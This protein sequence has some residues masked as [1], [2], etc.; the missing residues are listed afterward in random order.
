MPHTAAKNAVYFERHEKLAIALQNVREEIARLKSQHET[1]VA[2]SSVQSEFYVA[3]GDWTVQNV[4]DM[5]DLMAQI[6]NVFSNIQVNAGFRGHIL[7]PFLTNDPQ[8]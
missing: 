6:E 4:E 3:V 2:P 1:E 7:A 5:R 8:L